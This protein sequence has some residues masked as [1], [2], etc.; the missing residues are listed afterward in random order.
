M[1][2][3]EEKKRYEESKI[4]K[5]IQFPLVGYAGY[6]INCGKTGSLMGKCGTRHLSKLVFTFLTFKPVSGVCEECGFRCKKCRKV[7][8]PQHKNSH[9]C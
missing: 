1:G 2:Y 7:F 8:C 4:Q 9:Q 3:W 5:I 6:C